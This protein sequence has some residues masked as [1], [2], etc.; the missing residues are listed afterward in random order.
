MT[1]YAAVVRANHQTTGYIMASRQPCITIRD[2]EVRHINRRL[3]ALI[4]DDLDALEPGMSWLMAVVLCPGDDSHALAAWAK[5]A[6]APERVRFYLHPDTHV[7]DALAA[8]ADAGFAAAKVDVV[9][10][11]KELHPGFGRA[12]NDQVYADFASP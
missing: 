6:G 9:A 4:P 2:D 12:L 5:R 10:S 8:W 7:N 11:W 1:D 3:V